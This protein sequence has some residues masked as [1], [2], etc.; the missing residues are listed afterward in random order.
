MT[1]PRVE[2]RLRIVIY[3]EQAFFVAQCLEYDVRVQAKTIQ[4]VINY[5]YL[6]LLETK[7]DS[8]QRHGEAFA[9]IDPAPEQFHEMWK[10]RAAT[11]RPRR[12]AP[13][14]K[15]VPTTNDLPVALALA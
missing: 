7:H 8:L 1:K 12:N 2:K 9:H 4:E 10:H 6:A 5:I 15:L 3:Q 11:I 14:E 13:K